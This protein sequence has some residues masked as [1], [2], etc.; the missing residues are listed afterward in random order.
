[1]PGAKRGGLWRFFESF[2]DRIPRNR[3]VAS[4]ERGCELTR[5]AA[6]SQA[7]DVSNFGARGSAKK[8]Y[9]GVVRVVVEA[10]CSPIFA[11]IL[12]SNTKVKQWWWWGW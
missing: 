2:V 4:A 11:S 7:L 10:F 6:V 5:L 12:V 9:P 1:V 8:L 3:V